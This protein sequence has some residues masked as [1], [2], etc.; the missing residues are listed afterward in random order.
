[1]KG[2]ESVDFFDDWGT[3]EDDLILSQVD[4]PVFKNTV[5]ET[6]VMTNTQFLG[7]GGDAEQDNVTKQAS[8]AED[9][10]TNANVDTNDSIVTESWDFVD[11]LGD[12]DDDDILQ[13]A[14][15][16]IEKSQ[17]VTIPT[18]RRVSHLY[19]KPDMSHITS[20]QKEEVSDKVSPL[21]Q[22]D[23]TRSEDQFSRLQSN[24]IPQ[25]Q[26]AR[27]GNYSFVRHSS[28][29]SSTT[30]QT[31]N[32]TMQQGNKL[33][34]KNTN[35]FILPQMNLKRTVQR[36]ANF[37][38]IGKNTNQKTNRQNSSQ[39]QRMEHGKYSLDKEKEEKG[40]KI[41]SLNMHIIFSTISEVLG[42]FSPKRK[43]W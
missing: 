8:V 18:V 28:L 35:S 17:P 36:Q 9:H 23:V 37:Q 41:F 19:I 42:K 26:C 30:V 25:V 33:D 20:A 43:H 3:D 29:Q 27:K 39:G 31:K 10:R 32:P 4:I 5:P 11:E 34:V 13:N 40:I 2:N 16:D 38:N 6:Q 21:V 1:M 22:G 24:S 12:S 7:S 14:L 15:E